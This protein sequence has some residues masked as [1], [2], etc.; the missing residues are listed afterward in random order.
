MR[1]PKCLELKELN[2]RI[3]RA[4]HASTSSMSH[5]RFNVNASMIIALVR[6][7]TYFAGNLCSLF[8][9][10]SLFNQLEF[11]LIF[12][13]LAAKNKQQLDLRISIG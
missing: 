4:D 10:S 2:L 9:L 8:L 3:S 12:L 6:L 1:F 11:F 5:E 13:L 7:S